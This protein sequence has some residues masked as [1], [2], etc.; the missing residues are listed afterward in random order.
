M[1]GG[2]ISLD[3]THVQQRCVLLVHGVSAYYD[4]QVEVQ[5]D[6]QIDLRNTKE[7]YTSI[8]LTG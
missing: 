2:K 1:K 3:G 5:I 7:T 6:V 8:V 4:L